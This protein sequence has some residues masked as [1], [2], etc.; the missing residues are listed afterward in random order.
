MSEMILTTAD[1]DQQI[2]TAGKPVLV[3]FWAPWCGPCRMM[4]PA[5]AEIA[6][7]KAAT[8]C[9]AKVNVDDEGELAARFGINSIPCFIL[10]DKGQ[11]KARAVGAMGKE[12][13]LR[14]LGL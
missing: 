10:F 2:Q 11:E 7:E 13:L 9:V 4:A 12:G 1:F 3:D 8:L 14:A 6:E 5:V